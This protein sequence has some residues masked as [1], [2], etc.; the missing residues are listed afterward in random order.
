MIE[1]SLTSDNSHSNSQ[2]KRE[3]LAVRLEGS[4]IGWDDAARVRRRGT[5][6]EPTFRVRRSVPWS[7][8]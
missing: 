4:I 1:R 6:P 2:S 8:H 7:S 3:S 5:V